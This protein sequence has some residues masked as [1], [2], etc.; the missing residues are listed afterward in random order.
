MMQ[1]R[2]NK[3]MKKSTKKIYV[4][5]T[6]EDLMNMDDH[7]CQL[8]FALLVNTEHHELSHDRLLYKFL[9]DD[10]SKLRKLVD[11][12]NF[13]WEKLTEEADDGTVF[14]LRQFNSEED[15]DYLCQD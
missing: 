1:E 5:V 12:F 13:Y 10:F 11:L 9:E 6:D 2:E 4:K 15:I 14:D 7:M 8:I 3:R